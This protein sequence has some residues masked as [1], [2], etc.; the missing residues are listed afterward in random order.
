[1]TAAGLLLALLLAGCAG[2]RG[3]RPEPGP[4]TPTPTATIPA[5][6]ATRT[7][8][9]TPVLMPSETPTRAQDAPTATS[10]GV[11]SSTPTMTP[12]APILTPAPVA[13]A[14]PVLLGWHDV[15][16]GDTLWGIGLAWY[17][18]RFFAWGEDVWRPVCEA[19][20]DAVSDCR[21][22]YVGQRLRVP[23]R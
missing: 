17:Q 20:R 12:T 18:G 8:T 23:L 10:T 9:S 11:P 5:P 16:R 7:A 19:N 14:T 21:L 13:T 22:I 1:M 3:C 2:G 15:Q 4:G 6:P